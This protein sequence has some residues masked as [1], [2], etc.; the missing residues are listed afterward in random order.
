[1]SIKY[2]SIETKKY[3]QLSK[4]QNL[5]NKKGAP[6]KFSTYKTG[7]EKRIYRDIYPSI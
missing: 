2:V 7:T 1:M 5:S 6:F 4:I 3:L